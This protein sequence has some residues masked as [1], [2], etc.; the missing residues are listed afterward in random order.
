[1]DTRYFLACVKVFCSYCGLA[2]YEVTAAVNMG[3]AELAYPSAARR[4][5]SGGIQLYDRQSA[6]VCCAAACSPVQEQWEGEARTGR[7]G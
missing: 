6:S 2:A 3:P 4:K 1:M 7:G 5:N